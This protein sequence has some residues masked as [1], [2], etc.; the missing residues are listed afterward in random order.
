MKRSVYCWWY[1]ITFIAIR[2]GFRKS[3][4]EEYEWDI[5]PIVA[6]KNQTGVKL[7]SL[8][9]LGMFPSAHG[10]WCHWI[11]PTRDLSVCCFLGHYISCMWSRRIDENLHQVECM[12][13]ASA[14]SSVRVNK[15][16]VMIVQPTRSWRRLIPLPNCL[17][18]SPVRQPLGSRRH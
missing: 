12:W 1:W 7:D 3:D 11:S 9:G 16:R 18:D 14:L 4:S 2:A 8:P 15:P 13:L 17:Q 6:E 10:W 5:C